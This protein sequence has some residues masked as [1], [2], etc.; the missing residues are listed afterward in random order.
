MVGRELVGV[1][2]LMVVVTLFTF[3]IANGDKT[4]KV[5]QASAEGFAGLLR[6]VSQR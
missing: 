4:A 6:A 2:T 5:L 1:A 3:A